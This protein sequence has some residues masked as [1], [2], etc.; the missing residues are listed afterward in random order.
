MIIMK[1]VLIVQA[2]LAEGL[3]P[4]DR[5][6]PPQNEKILDNKGNWRDSCVFDDEERGFLC[7]NST[8]YAEQ[9]A[10]SRQRGG[11]FFGAF[12]QKDEIYN[13][14]DD[15]VDNP[16]LPITKH[17]TPET[18]HNGQPLQIYRLEHPSCE[19]ALKVTHV[20]MC[21]Q[22]AREWISPMSCVYLIE[23]ILLQDPELLNNFTFYVIP[24]ANPD[25]FD[26]TF[27]GAWT[28]FWRK[29]RRP[30]N[31]SDPGSGVGVDLNRNWGPALGAGGDWGWENSATATTCDSDLYQGPSASSENEV[32]AIVNFFKDIPVH[33]FF[34]I[35]AY[36]SYI[37][38]ALGTDYAVAT[39]QYKPSLNDWWPHTKEKMIDSIY[40]LHQWQ[41]EEWTQYPISGGANNFFS[42]P[43][44]AGGKGALQSGFEMRG[45][46]FQPPTS[47]ILPGSEEVYVGTR[48]F[49][50]RVRERLLKTTPAKL[51]GDAN[52]DGAVDILDV[53]VVIQTILTNG[54]VACGD[55]NKDAIVD[56]F[57]LLALI[58]LILA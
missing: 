4:I 31:A 2:I 20:Q 56:I 28:Y 41:Y 14:L 45:T 36:G 43:P 38:N 48:V 39:Q 46:S 9:V 27:Q 40:K 54:A 33:S 55:L 44:S 16:T 12:R 13:R 47:Y 50:Q 1:T 24:I 35:H 17:L 26:Y 10:A 11:D 51:N 25:G 52:A 29:N 21:T 7:V 3:A 5:T 37:F 34:D 49:I 19:S 23:R 30:C 6:L 57:D 53:V 32:R 15:L 8:L 18:T 58:T 22:H 42:S